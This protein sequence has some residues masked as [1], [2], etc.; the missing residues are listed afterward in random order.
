MAQPNST[1]PKGGDS[2]TSSPAKHQSKAVKRWTPLGFLIKL[3]LFVC[4]F[5]TAVLVAFFYAAG[6]EQGTEYLLNKIAQQ[7]GI[8]F[9]YGRGNLKDGIWI[10][11]IDIDANQDIHIGVDRVFVKIGWRAVFSKQV[12][13][14]EASIHH[15]VITNRQPPTDEPF[16]YK[17]L[18]LPI[19]LRFD[20]ADINRI[21]YNQASKDPIHVTDVAV[22]DLTWIG[23]QLKL[24]KGQ[25][26]YHD[27]LSV[28]DLTGDMDLKGTY[29]LDLSAVVHVNALDKAYV[30]A[31][32]ITAKGS[33]KRLHGTVN[34]QYNHAD[35]QG[36]F[37]AQPMDSNAPFWA[38]LRYEKLHLPYANEQ[39]IIL[40]DGLVIAS[41]I[42]SDIDLRINTQL[43]GQDIPT[44]H[45][46]GRAKV[47]VN[48]SLLD[49]KQLIADTPHGRLHADGLIDWSDAVDIKATVNSDDYALR[50]SLSP[51]YQ[52][53]QAYLPQKL[54]GTLDFHL[55]TQ[56]A[57][58]NLEMDMVLNQRDGEYVQANIIKVEDKSNNHQ[59]L[60][61]D[62]SWRQLKRQNLPDIGNINSDHGNVKVKMQGQR[63]DVQAN[64]Q[65]NEL[66]V[67]PKGNYVVNVHKMGS[68]ID[69]S[70]VD[71]QGV[72]GQLSGNGQIHLA[73]RGKPLNWQIHA[74]T[75]GLYPNRY[76]DN[77]P[78]DKLTG[79]IHA[80]GNL[81][82]DNH[83]NQQHH[84]SIQNSDLSALLDASQ[85]NR[86]INIGG[87][88]VANIRLADGELTAF[89]ADFDGELGTTDVPK[90]HIRLQANGTPN[91]IRFNELTY[92][93]KAGHLDGTGR[94]QLGGSRLSWDIDAKLQDLNTGYFITDNPTII[95]GKLDSQ[96]SWIKGKTEAET[97]QLGDFTAKFAGQVDTDKLPA[98]NLLV[99]IKGNAQVIDIN[100]LYHDGDAG[101]L[102]AKGTLDMRQGY[103]WQVNAEMNNFNLGYFVKDMPSR[104]SG[105]LD[106]TGSWQT[107]AQRIQIQ[108]MNVSG[109]L[110]GQPFKAQGAINVQMLLPKDIKGYLNRLKS[111]DTNS[112][113]NQVNDMIDAL[114]A[115]NLVIRW[116][117]NYLS[118][119]GDK[120]QL[121][122]K[123]N[124]TNLDQ[125]NSRLNGEISGG[126]T[127]LQTEN[128][129][130]PTLY[131]DVLAKRLA[132]PN[133]LLASGHVKGKLVDLGNSPSQLSVQ[134]V[135]LETA[136][137][138]INQLY[139]VFNGT[140]AKHTAQ[141]K[142]KKDDSRFSGLLTGEYDAQTM[143]WQGVM[144]QGELAS[145]GTVLKQQQPTQTV[146]DVDNQSLKMAA[147]CWQTN[148][149]AGQFCLNQPLN[150]NKN[151]GNVNLLIDN[152]DTKLFALAM[153][154]DIRWRAKVHGTAKLSWQQGQN[155]VIDAAIYSQNGKI[156]MVQDGTG[157]IDIPYDRVSLRL[158]SQAN[159]L[160]LRADLN[161]GQ[162]GNGYV[163]VLIN[164]TA[165]DKPIQGNLV[166]DKL[167]L[168]LFKPFFPGM[169]VLEGQA[170]ANGQL[171]GTLSTPKFDGKVAVRHGR[172][173]MLDMPVDLQ[174]I[175]ATADIQGTNADIKGR[176]MSGEGQGSIT[177]TIDWRNQ[178]I[179][180]LG[181]QGAQLSVVQP[182]ILSARINPDIEMIVRPSDK[183][184]SI[185][186]VITV[187]SATIRPPEAN[188]DIIGKSADVIVLDRRAVGNIEQVL[189][190]TKPWDINADIGVDL[191]HHV[192]FRGF[193]AVLPLAGAL[194][195][196]QHGQGIMTAKGM[197]QVA[198]RT[199]V[200][201]FG[202]SLDLNYAQVRFD[203]DIRRPTLSIEAVKEINAST[204]GLRVKG[205]ASNPNI[206]VFNDA[207]LSE[208]Q[209]M[210]ALVTGRIENSSATQIS[211]QGF[212]SE[213]TNNIA[214]AGLSYGLHG[215]RQFTNELGR[216][217]GL[218]SLT[219]NAA[220]TQDDTN[221]NVT[222][223]ITPDLYIRY[224]VGVF[225]AQSTLSVR[226][227]LT[228]RVYVEATSSLEKFVDVVYG[229]QF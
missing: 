3:F 142:A 63:L 116:A 218:Q 197:I 207:G 88:G 188:E 67:A 86:Q 64:A 103:H 33:L 84:I 113:Y 90:G 120:Q 163:N 118:V 141:V 109:Q 205:D 150:V 11:D 32:Q 122:A 68:R 146:L 28:H 21:T 24:G 128:S 175:N 149:K 216:A 227:Q 9:K 105:H 161:N 217:F 4:L 195:V 124:I 211:E 183:Y 112:Q 222:G 126:M 57:Q 208:Q 196:H 47:D 34:S 65:I 43:S 96:G 115:D 117:D 173:S 134:A 98:G 108:D 147:H 143:R 189:A 52:E 27:M 44:G 209:A 31:L 36:E 190:V 22:N 79:V 166:V 200:D 131:V 12:H 194:T 83:G 151:S 19:N 177:G 54:D 81:V 60:L 210:N 138:Q 160:K 23:T 184:I 2:Q 69:L 152:I 37:L 174:N 95:T 100:R 77:L 169:R 102:D 223:Y 110:K 199:N 85:D 178:L 180:K 93:G 204:V 119:S 228:K 50:Q 145:Q 140:M 111:A 159:G 75:E 229:W 132:L 58:G 164:P 221:V 201:A 168:A 20:A 185:K 186:G 18:Q 17:T 73:N 139:L 220:G 39:N 165:Q 82:V 215:T 66:N 192:T 5:F 25:L 41:G 172:V 219:V 127:M 106:S 203:G 1:D 129:R 42:T 78:I 153:P 125:L 213:V 155:P 6:T 171:S 107:N 104:L 206:I 8:G 182:P 94:V 226:Y 202:Q 16:D 7:T 187:P 26:Y 225:N 53:Y 121:Q 144:A 154:K 92:Q 136:N 170:T 14:R 157:N 15:L 55:L 148:D 13:L 101:K 51:E 224:G 156:G 61:I 179:A 46:Q 62:A 198:R 123:V 133:L 35:V 29:P 135:D 30:D 193:G 80:S 114:Q 40:Q 181:V 191:G 212:R 10:T 91:D 176:F 162:R 70:Q 45:Y 158:I 72:V 74:S 130:L 56:N 48:N 38:K 99:D 214:A 97:G 87:T 59:P 49:I 167:N 71:Y 137:Q 89:T 76:Q